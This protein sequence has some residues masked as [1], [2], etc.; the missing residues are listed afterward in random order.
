[1]I[2]SLP[3]PSHP[4]NLLQSCFSNS[5]N[6][7]IST[8]YFIVLLFTV[9][10][11]YTCSGNCYRVYFCY[12]ILRY[13]WNLNTDSWFQPRSA[14]HL[15]SWIRFQNRLYLHFA[16]IWLV[17]NINPNQIVCQ[18]CRTGWILNLPC[19][20]VSSVNPCVYRNYSYRNS[21]VPAGLTSVYSLNP[22]VTVRSRY[23]SLLE[24]DLLHFLHLNPDR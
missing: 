22:A 3:L 14:D 20:K 9:I 4:F 2:L 12:R 11:F 15:S 21:S 24:Y 1:M 8:S 23:T 6:Y 19:L 7:W 13:I 16:G 18:I 10:L 17:I 5:E